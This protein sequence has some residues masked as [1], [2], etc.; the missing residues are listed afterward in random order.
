MIV[1]LN[2]ARQ[3][4]EMVDLE[5]LMFNIITS[6]EFSTEPAFLQT[7]CKLFVVFSS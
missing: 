4:G 7:P 5:V 3:L 2:I 6:A 1:F